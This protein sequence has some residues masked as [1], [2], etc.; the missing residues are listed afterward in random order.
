MQAHTVIA[1]AVDSC[2]IALVFCSAGSDKCIPI[3]NTDIRPVGYHQKN[4]IVA[5]RLIACPNRETQIVTNEQLYF[6]PLIFKG[7]A[8]MRLPEELI[9]AAMSVQVAFVLYLNL[10]MWLDHEAAIAE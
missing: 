3:L 9:L 7:L 2:Y 8:L 4:I 1:Y 6:Y 10:R 5:A